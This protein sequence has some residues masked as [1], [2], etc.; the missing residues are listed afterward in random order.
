ML[1]VNTMLPLQPSFMNV[2]AAAVAQFHAP[3]TFSSNNFLTW[4]RVNSSAG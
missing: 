1:A 2:F 3:N 4:S